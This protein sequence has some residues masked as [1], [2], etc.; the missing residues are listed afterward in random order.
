MQIGQPTCGDLQTS[1]SFADAGNGSCRG[2]CDPNNVNRGCGPGQ[3]CSRL[4]VG[5]SMPAQSESV[6][7]PIPSDEDASLTVDAGG[8]LGG[9]DDVIA[10]PPSD[11]AH[12]A[13]GPNTHQ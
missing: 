8:G 2:Y 11:D 4:T 9:Y 5:G 13:D 10:L 7:V 6:C 3:M 12:V 1:V